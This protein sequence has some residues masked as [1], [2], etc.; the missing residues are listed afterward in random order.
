MKRDQ[1]LFMNLKNYKNLNLTYDQRSKAGSYNHNK[2]HTSKNQD[3]KP[4]GM[5]Q[6]TA[7]TN[8]SEQNLPPRSKGKRNNIVNQFISNTTVDMKAMN[9][10]NRN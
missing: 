8:E 1:H 4:I 6:M 10:K 5:A 9:L 7:L 2:P 3:F